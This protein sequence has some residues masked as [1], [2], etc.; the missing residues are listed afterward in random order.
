[1]FRRNKHRKED[2]KS[3]K[4]KLTEEELED[5]KQEIRDILKEEKN[6]DNYSKVYRE[7]PPNRNF[8]DSIRRYKDIINQKNKEHP[9]VENL[10]K[11]G[12]TTMKSVEQTISELNQ[13]VRSKKYKDSDGISFEDN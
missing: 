5:L 11:G 8:E 3:Y 9:L 7:Q 6:K 13:V 4:N 2:D 10:D 12:A 1:M